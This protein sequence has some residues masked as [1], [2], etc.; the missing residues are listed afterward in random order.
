MMSR[1]Q[2]D[3]GSEVVTHGKRI[4]WGASAASDIAYTGL[5]RFSNDLNR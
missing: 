1:R 4:R 2:V 5:E 3:P